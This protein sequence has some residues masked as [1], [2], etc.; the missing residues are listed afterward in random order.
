MAFRNHPCTA[1]IVWVVEGKIAAFAQ[2]FTRPDFYTDYFALEAYYE[3][4]YH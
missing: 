2:A 1:N 4:I 3:K